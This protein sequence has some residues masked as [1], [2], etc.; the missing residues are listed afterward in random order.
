M[1][2]GWEELASAIIMAA[3]K[4]YRRAM[5]RIRRCS[6]AKMPMERIRE[7]ERFFRSEWFRTLTEIDGEALIRKLRREAA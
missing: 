4:D 5:Q 2:N 1:I 6:G 7:C 3:V